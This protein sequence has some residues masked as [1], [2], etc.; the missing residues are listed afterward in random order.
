MSNFEDYKSEE[1]EEE[2]SGEE[3]SEEEEFEE[4]EFVEEEFFSS[5]SGDS[6]WEASSDE[7]TEWD[8]LN[9]AKFQVGKQWVNRA[10][11]IQQQRQAK[12]YRDIEYPTQK[13]SVPSRFKKCCLGGTQTKT[14][15]QKNNNNHFD[16]GSLFGVYPG[17]L[18]GCGLF[19][20]NNCLEKIF[21]FLTI[22]Q[23]PLPP[24]LSD[25]FDSMKEGICKVASCHACF[26]RRSHKECRAF[27]WKTIAY[28][29][30]RLQHPPYHGNLLLKEFGLMVDS[31]TI[32]I[33][34][35]TSVDV[36]GLGA[37]RGHPA[38][39]DGKKRPTTGTNA[40]FHMVIDLETAKY[41][42]DGVFATDINECFSNTKCKPH[43]QGRFQRRYLKG[44]KLSN[45]VPEMVPKAG[46]ACLEEKLKSWN[47]EIITIKELRDPFG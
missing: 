16:C 32:D 6:E 8:S 3:E 15:T 43:L 4:D 47:I 46:G 25:I 36:H 35:K 31:N 34:G 9:L 30:P 20:C 37:E 42:D 7:E 11:R 23:H 24:Y 13:K 5:S 39:L 27:N 18:C 1:F 45:Y 17:V 28:Q 10:E 40:P 12:R 19:M 29:G 41:L 33:A 14:N 22:H 38:S 26:L 2:E 44:V 21:D